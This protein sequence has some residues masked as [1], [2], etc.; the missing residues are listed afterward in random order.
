MTPG[1]RIQAAIELDG[2]IEAAERPADVVI[3]A[4]FRRRRYAGGGDR[5][6]VTGRVFDLLRRRSRLE[7]WIERLG[8]GLAPGPRSRVIV[9][10][11]LSG[12]VQLEALFDGSRFGPAPL[13]DGERR[14]LAA[15]PTL[16]H[17]EM[18]DWVA[19]E[20]PRWLD[21]ELDASMAAMNRPAP[22]DVRV[23]TLKGGRADAARSLAGDGI[24]ARP[25]PLSPLGLRLDGHPSL[26]ATKAFG[27]GLIEVQDEGSQLVALYCGAE[28]GMTVV[29]LCAGGGGKTLALAAAMEGRGELVACDVDRRRLAAI[30]PRIAR[31]GAGNVRIRI[32]EAGEDPW[33]AAELVLVDA[34]CSR[35]GAWRRDVAARWRLRPADLEALVSLQRAILAEAA[36]LVRPGGRLVYA[37]CSLLAR[38]NE[39][40]V[41]RFLAVEGGFAAAPGDFLRLSPAIS[42]TDGFF[43]ATLERRR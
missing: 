39:A 8:E 40:Q 33:I 29:D 26:K 31:S 12:E 22:L 32:L 42:G 34:P 36:R 6:A 28:P 16:D 15:G 10:L 30:E 18:P 14:L 17:P 5:R 7:W 37:T 24:E 23:N 2:E 20:Y 9:D 13:D 1:A 41:E 19:G 21:G 38:E 25:T 35:S 27:D 11:A 3:A 43:A 4:Y